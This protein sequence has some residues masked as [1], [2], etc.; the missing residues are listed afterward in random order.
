MQRATLF[1]LMSALVAPLS[2]V[3]EDSVVVQVPAIISPSAPIPAAVKEQCD[4]GTMLSQNVLSV[5]S[6]RYPSAQA[7]AS[8]EQAGAATLVQLTVLS[9]DGYGGGVFSGNK[10]ITIKAEVLKGG[11]SV[12]ANVFMRE[13]SGGIVTFAT[14]SLL[15]KA[16][17]ALGKDVLKLLVRAPAAAAAKRDAD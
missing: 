6:K 5:I 13:G 9:V 12:S 10:S 4:V 11:A 2:A 17:R 16:A 15:E 3:A 14:C 7:V 1:F 8:A